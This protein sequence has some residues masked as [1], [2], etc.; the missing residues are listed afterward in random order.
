VL[1]T[2]KGLWVL[3]G[4]DDARAPA[5]IMNVMTNEFGNFQEQTFIID[6]KGKDLQG[7]VDL[8]ELWHLN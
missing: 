3:D 1:I 6:M 4:V 2:I 7:I 8:R 5:L